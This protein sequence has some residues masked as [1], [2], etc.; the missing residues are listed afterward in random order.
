MDRLRQVPGVEAASVAS[1]LP[2]GNNGWQTSFTL[3]G[4]PAPAPGQMP[5]MEACLVSSDYFRAMSIPL[6]AGR[7]FNEQDNR[8]HLKGRDLSGL[9]E[10]QRA[11]MAV[12]A[13]VIDE[14]FARRYW[15]NQDAVGQRI[16]LGG[17]DSSN[18]VLTVIGVVG[19]VKMESLSGGT[20]YVQGYFC[21]QQLPFSGMTAVIKSRVEPSSLTAAVRAQVTALDPSQP[22]FNI[23]TM[24]QIRDES[25]ATEKL[26]VMLLMI[27]AAVA[28][29]LA[30][31]GIYGVMSYA[32]TQRTHEIGIRLA[33]GA[34]P[35]DVLRLVVGQGMMLTSAG[36]GI[37]LG[38]ALALTWLM[39][40]LLFGTSATDPLTFTIVATVL[41][42][43]A[44]VACYVPARRAAKVDPLIALRYE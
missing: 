9:S 21:S 17:A 3:E 8:E 4:R 6:K 12:N 16:R 24:E 31:V 10:N 36:I 27:F 32:V 5:L 2:L 38:L 11:G 44:F 43:V 41:A 34:Q 26:N 15:P 14:E 22:I 37:G 40:A 18:P 29:V 35:G 20:D 39:K 7:Y 13:I 25:V 19:R 30:L 1:G 28:L 42:F 33:L 23:R